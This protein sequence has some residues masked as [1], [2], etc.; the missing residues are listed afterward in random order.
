MAYL[1]KMIRELISYFV[2]YSYLV[3]FNGVLV[4]VFLEGVVDDLFEDLKVVPHY[5]TSLWLLIGFFI[6]QYN[7]NKLN[8]IGLLYFIIN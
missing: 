2:T 7:F 1:I 8:N 4:L 5:I 6:F 3:C